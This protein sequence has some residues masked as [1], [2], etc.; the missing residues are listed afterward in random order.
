MKMGTI[1][2]INTKKEFIESVYSMENPILIRGSCDTGLLG[3][4]YM[5]KD[6]KKKCSVIL[7]GTKLSNKEYQLGQTE[8]F[9]EREIKLCIKYKNWMYEVFGDHYR[10]EYRE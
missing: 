8:K 5:V 10:V 3:S 7:P 1:T 4:W 2:K 9:F 6:E